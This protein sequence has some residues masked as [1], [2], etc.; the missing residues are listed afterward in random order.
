MMANLKLILLVFSLVLFALS[1][2]WPVASPDN[3]S[4]VR[5]IGAGLT[6]YIAS[7][8]FG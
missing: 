8:L 6:F 2:G 1:A 5:L 3:P 4:R 7:I